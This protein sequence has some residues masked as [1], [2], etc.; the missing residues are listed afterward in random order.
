MRKEFKFKKDQAKA[1][2]TTKQTQAQSK[3][4]LADQIENLSNQQASMVLNE[5]LKQSKMN[6]NSDMIEKMLNE[7]MSRMLSMQPNLE[8]NKPK[9]Q[10][11]NEASAHDLNR[12]QID[13]KE[14][15]VATGVNKRE[16]LL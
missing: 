8:S 3:Q 9:H 7:V 13:S 2:S 1:K 11:P 5:F 12:F 10:S 14:S 6:A 4:F 16:T 15:I